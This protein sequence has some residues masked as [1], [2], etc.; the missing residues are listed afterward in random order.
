[1]PDPT[2]SDALAEAYASAPSSAVIIDTL[3]FYYPGLVDDGD[4][5][6][7]F[8]IYAGFEGDSEDADGIPIKAFR[9]EAGASIDGGASVDFR[10][11]PFRIELPDAASTG[12]VKGKLIVDGVSREATALML[13]AIAGGR[14]ITVTYR[15]Y[16]TGNED[17]GPEND[18]PMQFVLRNVDIGAVRVEAEIAVAN[19]ANKA[20]PSQRYTLDRFPMLLGAR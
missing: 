3:S 13:D 8:R 6:T 20:F 1:M 17:I 4:A 14:Q 10:S 18:P 16:L 2:L 7:E 15:A 9:L 19:I 5:P 12:T 11:M